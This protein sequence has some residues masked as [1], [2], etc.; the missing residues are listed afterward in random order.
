[1]STRHA[2][3]RSEVRLFCLPYAGGTAQSI[4]RDWDEELPGQVVVHPLELPGRGRLSHLKPYDNIRDVV[5]Y[6][7]SVIGEHRDRP[8]AIFGHSMG[9][10]VGFELARH[11]RAVTGA[12]PVALFVSGYAA[13]QVKRVDKETHTLPDDSLLRK[14]ERLGGLPPGLTSDA[15]LLN[16]LLPVIRADLAVCDT[17]R[18]VERELLGE[19]IFVFGGINDPIVDVSAL[20]HW[21]DETSADCVVK[22]FHGGHFFIDVSRSLVAAAIAEGLRGWAKPS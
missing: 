11:I 12:S 18:Y 5:E 15:S 21:G 14:I 9:A 4:Y 22:T 10:L 6:A 7:A 8:F 1:M 2:S 20:D 13:P 17:Y 16:Y 19:P 3:H